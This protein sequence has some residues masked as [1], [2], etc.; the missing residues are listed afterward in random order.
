MKFELVNFFLQNIHTP[1]LT[2]PFLKVNSGSLIVL[3]G[4]AFYF[5]GYFI[6]KLKQLIFLPIPFFFCCW[7]WNVYG[8][9][10]MDYVTVYFAC[11]LAGVAMHYLIT[12][13]KK[14]VNKVLPEEQTNNDYIAKIEKMNEQ[15]ANYR[16][17]N[18]NKKVTH[19]IIENIRTEIFFC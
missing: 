19:E 3:F 10:S 2:I 14:Y 17:E 6:A 16:K 4:I 7:Y 12:E 15:I 8:F 1:F 9:M 11:L 5:I 18:P 13:Y